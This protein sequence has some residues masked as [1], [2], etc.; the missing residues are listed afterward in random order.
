MKDKDKITQSIKS[1]LEN[2]NLL[3]LSTFDKKHIS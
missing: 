2:N 3:T 1:I